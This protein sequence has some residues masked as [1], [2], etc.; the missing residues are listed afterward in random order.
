MKKK[1]HRKKYNKKFWKKE[2]WVGGDVFLI[3]CSMMCGQ[4]I[5]SGAKLGTLISV[6]IFL[7]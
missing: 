5:G 3:S 4:K 2:I 6:S 1:S 7:C